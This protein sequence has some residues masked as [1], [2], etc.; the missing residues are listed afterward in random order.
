[1]TLVYFRRVQV[2]C[3]VFVLALTVLSCSG[4]KREPFAWPKDVENLRA[5]LLVYIPEGRE[6][7][8]A[9]QW[10]AEH[11]FACEPP[12]P[13][14]TDAHAHVCHAAQSAPA[15]AGWRSWTVVLYERR[16]RL[17]DVSARR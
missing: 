16:G 8:G 11:G 17:Q 9:R 12:L 6:I 3:P 4:P 10:M 7:E 13:S 5:R 1:V 2:R 14:A 15:D